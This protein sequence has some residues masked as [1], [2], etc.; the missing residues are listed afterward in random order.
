MP[1]TSESDAGSAGRRPAAVRPGASPVHACPGDCGRD[2]K[3]DLFACRP[4][5]YRLPLAL[6]RSITAAWRRDA[7]AHSQHMAT[8]RAWYAND[9]GAQS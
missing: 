5:W 6:R 7:A 3:V 1:C 2:V 4:C 8:A 9:A